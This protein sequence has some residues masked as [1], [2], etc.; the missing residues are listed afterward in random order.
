MISGLASFAVAGLLAASPASVVHP[1]GCHAWLVGIQYPTRATPA[2]AELERNY[3]Q[4]KKE[5]RRLE[6][7]L[8]PVR[9]G[10]PADLIPHV[11]IREV[12]LCG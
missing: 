5:E 9:P 12:G 8:P 4:A 1:R 3:G 2:F 7:S 6:A 11:F 10:T